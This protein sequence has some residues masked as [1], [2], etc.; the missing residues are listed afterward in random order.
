[1]A[2]LTTMALKDALAV[3]QAR[4]TKVITPCSLAWWADKNRTAKQRQPGAAVG[5]IAALTHDGTWLI[6]Y[7]AGYSE[8]K[9]CGLDDRRAAERSV[10][11]ADFVDGR[12]ERK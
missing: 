6:R 7:E 12:R 9:R 2:N 3:L 10:A 1:M 11:V 5:Q 4:E 8:S